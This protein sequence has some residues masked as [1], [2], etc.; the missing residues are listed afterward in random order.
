MIIRTP[1]ALTCCVPLRT[2]HKFSS[3]LTPVLCL[4][5][6]SVSELLQLIFSSTSQPAPC[7]EGSHC[8]FVTFCL[9]NNIS[10]SHRRSGDRMARLAGHLIRQQWSVSLALSALYDVM[11]ITC[12]SHVD[13]HCIIMVG[14]SL[15]SGLPRM[16]KPR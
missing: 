15:I 1:I 6:E 8:I 10:T 11:S 12:H 3:S 9:C 16:R 14:A 13:C 2:R 7:S 4:L 5:M